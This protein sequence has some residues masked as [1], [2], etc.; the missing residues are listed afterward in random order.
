M[1]PLKQGGING[2]ESE[3]FLFENSPYSADEIQAS[4]QNSFKRITLVHKTIPERITIDIDL[5]FSDT[6][7]KENL[8]LP[9]L[10]VIE[11]K[12][13]RDSAQS[14]MIKVLHK[15]HIRSMGFSKYCMGTA[16]INSNVKTNLLRTTMRRI[17][18]YEKNF[19]SA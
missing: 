3:L 4:L 13:D 14:D 1:R 2:K 6:E 11:V 7:G 9:N 10:S 19:I 5:L 17:G 12:R 18:K 8:S 16:L 15:N